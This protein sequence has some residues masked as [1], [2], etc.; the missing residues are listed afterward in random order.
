MVK[1]IYIIACRKQY[2]DTLSSANL[3]PIQAENADKAM[4]KPLGL[5]IE[6]FENEEPAPEWKDMNKIVKLF[7][8]YFLGHL[9]KMLNIKN[10]YSQSYEEEMQKYRV[11]IDEIQDSPD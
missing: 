11:S 10:C 5:L 4:E 7:N 9:C 3:K 1:L 6:M 8:I 2:Q